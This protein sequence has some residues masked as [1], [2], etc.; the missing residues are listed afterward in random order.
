ML[1]RCLQISVGKCTGGDAKT[2]SLIKENIF[3]FV[4][5]ICNSLK[6]LVDLKLFELVK[7]NR[8]VDSNLDTPTLFFC[9]DR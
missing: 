5:L 4:I 1:S 6:V 9:R 2:V 3:T 7:V 8:A